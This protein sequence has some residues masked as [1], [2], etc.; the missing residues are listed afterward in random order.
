MLFALAALLPVN[1]YAEPIPELPEIS[2]AVAKTAPDL[3]RQRAELVSKRNSLHD[4]VNRHNASCG[5]VDEGSAEEEKCLRAYEDIAAAV[6]SH[7]KASNK[8]L[9]AYDSAVRQIKSVEEHS[10]DAA[11][12]D[13]EPMSNEAR[14][15]LDTAGSDRWIIVVPKIYGTMPTLL[16]KQV[17]EEAHRDPEIQ[18]MLKWYR[19]LEGMKAAVNK[20]I[21]ALKKQQATSK[22]PLLA[23]KIEQ[24]N[25]KLKKYASDQ[26]VV[27]Q[28]AKERVKKLGYGYKW[29]ETGETKQQEGA[30]K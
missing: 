18:K 19:Q 2:A 14:K 27:T 30:K 9:E 8:Y 11:G 20:E 22:D 23:V 4:R 29:N 13:K 6:D 3:V 1:V 15:R 28:N 17:P 7:I 16:D 5:K 10:K 12:L 26:A 25:N 21:A 24:Y